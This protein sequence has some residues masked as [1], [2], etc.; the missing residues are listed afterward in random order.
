MS[1]S[2]KVINSLQELDP[3]KV[4]AIVVKDRVTREQ[5]EKLQA[6]CDL[7]GIKGLILTNSVVIELE[8]SAIIVNAVMTKLRGEVEQQVREEAAQCE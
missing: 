6:A 8:Q 7:L 5:V 3:N 4:Y 2:T 1:N